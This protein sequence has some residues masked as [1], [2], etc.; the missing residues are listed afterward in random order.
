M[1]HGKI[2]GLAAGML[3]AFPASALAQDDDAGDTPNQFDAM[4]ACRDI[5]D[6]SARL[7][8]YDN[9]I[10]SV[11]AATESGELQIV[12]RDDVRKT[13]RRLFGFSLPDIGLFGGGDDEDDELDMLE[14]TVTSVRQLRRDAWVFQTEEG[15]VWQIND[16]PMRLRGPQVGQTVVFKKAS[17]GSYFIRINGQIGVKGRRI[18]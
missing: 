10:A 13:R 8:C 7:A 15:A 9:A 12:D 2:A 17:F 18:G 6:D 1:K 3:L 14:T 4:T 11:V 16:A 5:A